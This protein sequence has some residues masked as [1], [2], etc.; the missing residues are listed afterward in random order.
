MLICASL[1][2]VADFQVEV[3]LDSQKHKQ[4]SAV[5]R[6]LFLDSHQPLVQRSVRVRHGERVCNQTKIYLRVRPYSLTF[7][8][9]DYTFCESTVSLFVQVVFNKK[10]KPYVFHLLQDEKEFRDKLSPIYVA[11]NFSLDPKAAADSHG[12]R[13]ILNYQTTNIY[14]QKVH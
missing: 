3:R 6:A 13:P 4:R 8:D 12:L 1:L 10:K 9:W 11:L 2:C 5:K 14:E 7:Y